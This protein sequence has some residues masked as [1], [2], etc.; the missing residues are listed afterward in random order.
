[1]RLFIAWVLLTYPFSV[2]LSIIVLLLLKNKLT[3][4]SNA[5][6]FYIFIL[7]W[8]AIYFLIS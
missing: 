4:N 8:W 1:M 3:E 7:I 2:L 5:S 6:V